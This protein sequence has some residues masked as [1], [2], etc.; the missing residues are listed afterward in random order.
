M[1]NSPALSLPQLT[2]LLHPKPVQWR[3]IIQPLADKLNVPIVDAS[4]WLARL[5]AAKENAPSVKEQ[6]AFQLIDFYRVS[7]A[8]KTQGADTVAN[9][10]ALGG[11]STLTVKNILQAS[12]TLG[13][14]E[15]EALGGT[16]V[17]KWLL[18]WKR[19]GVL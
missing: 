10:E 9:E 12:Q 8:E 3:D 13:D 1:R 2:H 11:G 18:Y 7:L 19:I 15:L 4:I 6:P 17:D 16:D 14:P 5:E